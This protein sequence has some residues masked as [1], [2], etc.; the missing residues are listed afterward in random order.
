VGFSNSQTESWIT[1]GRCATP[2]ERRSL[3]ALRL[4]WWYEWSDT[5]TNRQCLNTD[6]CSLKEQNAITGR[7][8]LCASAQAH[9]GNQIA[10]VS[11]DHARCH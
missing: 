10:F 9:E 5:Q 4:S 11:T 1:Q 6:S 2:G 7:H 3:E 8:I